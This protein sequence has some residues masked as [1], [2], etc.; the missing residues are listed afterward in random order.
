MT[1]IDLKS[2]GAETMTT[3]ELAKLE[4]D[5]ELNARHV[6]ELRILKLQSG[7]DNV[8]DLS[9]DWRQKIPNRKTIGYYRA[10][11]IR[12]NFPTIDPI[13]EMRARDHED[14]TRLTEM[15]SEVARFTNDVTRIAEVV[16]AH[17]RNCN[18]PDDV[19]APIITAALR[20]LKTNGKHTHVH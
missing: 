5:L 12:P 9:D 13:A 6:R 17:A 4:E 8:L 19:S 1:T 18:I 3:S 16:V 14:P 2:L 7:H 11:G 15:V 20:A 10:K